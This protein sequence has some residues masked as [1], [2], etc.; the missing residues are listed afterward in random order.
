MLTSPVTDENPGDPG[1]LPLPIPGH[2]HIWDGLQ[3]I[4][5]DGYNIFLLRGTARGLAVQTGDYVTSIKC[6]GKRQ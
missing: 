5:G 6:Q 1:P 4:F 3:G 2:R